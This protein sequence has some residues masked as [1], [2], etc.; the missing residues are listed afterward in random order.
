MVHPK[1][2]PD[3][4]K[5]CLGPCRRKWCNLRNTPLREAWVWD[6]LL[7]YPSIVLCVFIFIERQL[8]DRNGFPP[9]LCTV[10]KCRKDIMI[11]Y[12]KGVKALYFSGLAPIQK[13]KNLKMLA[14]LDSGFQTQNSNW[15]KIYIQWFSLY[16]FI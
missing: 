3:I 7:K 9:L 16:Q 11:G 1:W 12:Y 13:N 14:T 15:I 4:R 6:V 8:S 5:V 2:E 10:V